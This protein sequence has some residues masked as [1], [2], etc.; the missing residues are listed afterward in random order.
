MW[1]WSTTRG[2]TG[3]GT[4]PSLLAQT[5]NAIQELGT[6]VRSVLGVGA[7]PAQ[8]SAATSPPA[9]ASR[10]RTTRP[11]P[12]ASRATVIPSEPVQLAPPLE[13]APVVVAADAQVAV[14]AFAPADEVPEGERLI[15]VYSSTDLDVRPALLLYPQLPPPLLAERRAGVVNSMELV[16]SESGT[17]VQVRLIDGP[18]RMPDMML[19]SGAKMWKFR[20]AVKDG[21]PVRYRTVVS[22]SGIP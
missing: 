14:E 13:L 17:V 18:R 10:P 21:E 5:K 22:W 8:R 7:A 16:V 9:K 15:P 19:L 1:F 12:D 20:P 11:R 6:E 2:G 3:A 4:V